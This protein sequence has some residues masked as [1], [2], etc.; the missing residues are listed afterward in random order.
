MVKHWHR[1]PLE[2]V[3]SPSLQMLRTHLDMALGNLL[4]V[5]LLEHM[6]GLDGLQRSLPASPML[7]KGREERTPLGNKPCL[8][9]WEG[10]S[11]SCA[12]D[13][14][15]KVL[16]ATVWCNKDAPVPGSVY[17]FAR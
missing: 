13:V 9:V 7:W 12:Q 17:S 11:L 6:V 2:V 16:E 10:G 5:T 8:L 14:T 3:E 4:P 15:R 1:L